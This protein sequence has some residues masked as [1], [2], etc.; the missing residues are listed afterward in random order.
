M[1]SPT[2]CS[3]TPSKRNTEPHLINATGLSGKMARRTEYPRRCSPLRTGYLVSSNFHF[4][5]PTCSEHPCLG[6]RGRDTM[7]GC[8]GL[9]HG[10]SC[11]IRILRRGQLEKNLGRFARGFL[12]LCPDLGVESGSKP[13]LLQ[14]IFNKTADGWN[15]IEFG[16]C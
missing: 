7:P 3:H 9:G 5:D 10:T 12:D 16:L 4:P 2:P 14:S 6:P 8:P 15:V 13:R 1:A 11:P